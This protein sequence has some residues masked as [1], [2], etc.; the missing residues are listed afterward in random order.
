MRT[1]PGIEVEKGSGE[2]P[3]SLVSK[4]AACPKDRPLTVFSVKKKIKR[5]LVEGMSALGKTIN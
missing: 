4:V 3:L 2:D 1:K 5:V